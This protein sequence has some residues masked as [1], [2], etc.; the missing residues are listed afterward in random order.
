[1]YETASLVTFISMVSD[2]NGFDVK[3]YRVLVY[4]FKVEA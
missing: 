4:D 1:M 2:I 3:F